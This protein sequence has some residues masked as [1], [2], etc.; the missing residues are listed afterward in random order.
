MSQYPKTRSF[1]EEEYPEYSLHD[2][3]KLSGKA[4]KVL[5]DAGVLGNRVAGPYVQV[6]A[7]TLHNKFLKKSGD[8]TVHVPEDDPARYDAVADRD[9][10]KRNR[11]AAL[12]DMLMEYTD[13]AIEGAVLKSIILTL[14][15]WYEE[16]RL[17]YPFLRWDGKIRVWAPIYVRDCR[18]IVTKSPKAMYEVHLVSVAGPTAGEE[19]VV[20]RSAAYLQ[21]HL[22]MVGL[23]KYEEYRSDDFGGMW[24]TAQL[25]PDD[26]G[27]AFDLTC[28]SAS[29]KTAN[30]KLNKGRGIPCDAFEPYKGKKCMTCPVGRDKCPRSRLQLGY[31]LK[32]Q[33]VNEHIGYFRGLSETICFACSIRPPKKSQE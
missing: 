19:W 16:F 7:E 6:L 11:I 1:D 28:V 26:K 4:L 15:G 21:G 32:R 22:R 12:T 24:F 30:R 18:R 2:L 23:P 29:Q 27:I 33:C 8:Y 3:Q 5:K 9:D 10:L 25:F 31:Y 17:G 20:V 14:A 13:S